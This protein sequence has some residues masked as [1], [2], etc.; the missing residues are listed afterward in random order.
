MSFLHDDCRHW[1]RY[2]DPGKT[3][4]NTQG[5]ALRRPIAVDR[6]FHLQTSAARKC[7]RMIH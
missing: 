5:W 2:A 7:Q 4:A 3:S 6:P 1:A